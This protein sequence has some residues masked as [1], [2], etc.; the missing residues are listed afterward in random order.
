M[1]RFVAL[2]TVAHRRCTLLRCVRFMIRCL[3][4]HFIP[5]LGDLVSQMVEVYTTTHHSCFLYL[6]SVLVDEFGTNK[7]CVPG[8]IQMLEVLDVGTCIIPKRHVTS[9]MGCLP[10]VSCRSREIL[11]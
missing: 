1:W 6:G 9:Q 3:G 8:L 7:Q 2:F 5:L 4:K 10:E 11:F